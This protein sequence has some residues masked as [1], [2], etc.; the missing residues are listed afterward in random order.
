MMVTDLNYHLETRLVEKLDKMIKRCTDPVSRKDAVLIIEGGEGEGKTNSSEAISYYVSY[1]MKRPIH[2]FFRLKNLI[3]FAQNTENKIIIWDE[4]ALDSLSTDWFKESNKDL[5]RLVMSCRKKRH[6]FIFNFVRF[7]KFPEYLVVDRS[8]G[9]IHMYTRSKTNESGRFV[10]IR[11]KNLEKLFTLY[12]QKKI[13]AYG[14]LKNFGG[15]MPLVEKFI[16]SMHLNIEGIENA[17]L[18]DYERQKDKAIEGI[19]EKPAVDKNTLKF[20]AF[21]ATVGKL[22]CPIT[23]KEEL[24]NQLGVSD[25]TLRNWSKYQVPN[26]ILYNGDGDCVE[27]N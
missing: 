16:P 9:L 25:E 12:K 26:D 23:T 1:N 4:P 3:E 22:K 10:Y 13:R 18:E 8:L 6:F 11:Q 20:K 19:G 15:Y 5:L 7:Y 14:S 2:M 27:Q 17:T 24:A 21:K